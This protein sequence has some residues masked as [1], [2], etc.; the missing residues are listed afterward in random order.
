MGM[1]TDFYRTLFQ[2][3]Q[4]PRTKRCREEVWRH[5]PTIV[6][7][8]MRTTLVAPFSTAKMQDAAITIDGQKDGLSKTFFT[9]Y[10]N[11][12]HQPLLA[13]FQ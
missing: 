8:N 10:W 9:S 3:K 11:Q 6:Q 4:P 1:A 5:T 13:A 7:P 12:I 2:Q